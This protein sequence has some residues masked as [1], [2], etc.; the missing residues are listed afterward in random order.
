MKLIST[1]FEHEGVIPSKYTCDGENISPDLSFGSIPTE[2]KSLVLLM[3]DPDVPTHL[4]EGGVF[5]HWIL[6][7]IPADTSGLKEGE[8]AGTAGRNSAGSDIYVGPCPP[9]QFQPAEHRYIFQLYALNTE[10]DLNEGASKDAVKVAMKGH[11]LGKG[12][13]LG[14][15]SRKSN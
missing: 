2:A 4:R 11:I 15:Y 6:F 10:L 5:D 8:T 14:R 13:L 1:A 12:E 9:P 3:D 7:N